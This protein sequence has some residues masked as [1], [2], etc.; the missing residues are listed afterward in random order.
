[1]KDIKF[2]LWDGKRMCKVELWDFR[3]N[4]VDIRGEDGK[5]RYLELGHE[6][7]I[8][9]FTG[10]KDM[11]GKDIYEGDILRF[12][13]GNIAPIVFRLGCF[14]VGH[15]DIDFEDDD[16][17]LGEFVD[18]YPTAKFEVVGN[19]YENAEL[20]TSKGERNART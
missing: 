5:G 1:M 15:N 8:M 9:Q 3:N 10:F 4:G 13:R 6:V 20:I 19:L 18:G 11:G 14:F 12:E 2:R 17:P 7:N 16:T